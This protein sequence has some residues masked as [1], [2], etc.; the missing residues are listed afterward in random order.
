MLPFLAVPVTTVN[1]YSYFEGL[2]MM[3]KYINVTYIRRILTTWITDGVKESCNENRTL[4]SIKNFCS[5][6]WRIEID[7]FG[8]CTY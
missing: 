6:L 2:H 3:F 4:A 1:E 7:V 8:V 5:F